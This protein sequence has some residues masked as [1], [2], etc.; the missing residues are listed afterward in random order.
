M[1]MYVTKSGACWLYWACSDG[2]RQP[3]KAEAAQHPLLKA[4][5]DR[6]CAEMVTLHAT[7]EGSPC[8]REEGGM[9]PYRAPH[10]CLQKEIWAERPASFGCVEGSQRKATYKMTLSWPAGPLPNSQRAQRA[11][12]PAHR[13]SGTAALCLGCLPR[14]AG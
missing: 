13:L 9:L 6:V 8:G 10:P 12:Q 1:N 2:L 7:T 5:S 11:C 4:K 3:T 14:S